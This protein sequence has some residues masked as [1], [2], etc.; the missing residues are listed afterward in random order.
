MAHFVACSIR[1]R[2]SFLQIYRLLRIGWHPVAMG[3]HFRVFEGGLSPKKDGVDEALARSLRA[4][5]DWTPNGAKPFGKAER[6]FPAVQPE[7]RHRPSKRKSRKRPSTKNIGWGSSLLTIAPLALALSAATFWGVW[8]LTPGPS[9][10]LASASDM[11]SGSFGFCHEGGGYN[12]V[13]DGDTLYYKG[14]KIRIADIDTPETH[15]PRCAAE[16]TQGAAATERLQELVNAGPFSLSSI[17]R[18]E[19]SYGRKL[20]VVSRGG[21]SLGGVLVD[22]GLAR[23]YA[24]GRRPWC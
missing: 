12:C 15:D 9:V 14:T 19:D 17:D 20:R 7:P 8:T 2:S 11:E 22:E 13:V 6:A 10:A 1:N 5:L 18:D 16:A 4:E 23:W 21:Q 24:G 3:K